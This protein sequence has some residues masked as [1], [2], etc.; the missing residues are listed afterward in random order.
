[1]KFILSATAKTMFNLKD[2]LLK[3]KHR[4]WHSISYRLS[5]NKHLIGYIFNID[6]SYAAFDGYIDQ[7]C[8][9]EVRTEQHGLIGVVNRL[10]DLP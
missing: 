8:R 9:F 1:M 7:A 3:L 5:G 10:D 2:E 6:G 4:G